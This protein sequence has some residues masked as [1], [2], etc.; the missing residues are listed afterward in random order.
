M[1]PD[2]K[3]Y[4]GESVWGS[5]RKKSLGQEERLEDSTRIDFG[6]NTTVYWAQDA[7]E[8]DGE[9]QFFFEDVENYNHNGWRLPT[10][11]E[12]KQVD[13]SH[14][15]KSWYRDDDG[16]GYV[17][18][19]YPNGTLRIKTE[20][21]IY[22]FGMWTKDRSK[23]WQNHAYSYGYDNMSK[24]KIDTYLISQTRLYVFLVKDK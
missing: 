18:L 7:L 22:G 5:I 19:Q 14:I 4:V 15:R 12:V 11:Q 21:S 9:N 23:E 24:F 2:F 17:W 6:P 16:V 3:T 10:V 8:I 13:F 1:I 20:N